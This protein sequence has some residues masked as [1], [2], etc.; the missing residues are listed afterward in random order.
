MLCVDMVLDIV[1]EPP[2]QRTNPEGRKA[3]PRCQILKPFFAS[4]CAVHNFVTEETQS[5]EGVADEDGG[6]QFAHDAAQPV[7]YGED[8]TCD[9]QA[10][11]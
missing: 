10:V 4:D 8:A 7:D 6:N 9:D 11:R 3:N 2:H 5:G 1:P